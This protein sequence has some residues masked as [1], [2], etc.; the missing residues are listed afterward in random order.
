MKT[1]HFT[2]N[3]GE[4]LA[5]FALPVEPCAQSSTVVEPMGNHRLSSGFRRTNRVTKIRK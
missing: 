2:Y 1:W 4:T 5:R 3:A